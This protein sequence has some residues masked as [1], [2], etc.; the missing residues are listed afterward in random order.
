MSRHVL[1]SRM[2]NDGDVLLTTPA[3]RAIQQNGSKVSIL[4]SPR[5][6]QAAQLIPNIEEIIIFHTP[7][8]DSDPK[9]VDRDK[10][11]ELIKQIESISIDEAFIF[12]SFH[13]SPLPMALLLRLASVPFIAAISEDY[14]GS[15]LD[16]R[17]KVDERLHEVERNLSLVAT[18]GY[19]LDKN[20]NSQLQIKP[21]DSNPI[22]EK[23]YIVVHPGASVP[24]RAWSV[25][26]NIQ[27]VAALADEGYQ[28]VVTGA[29]K[30]IALTA[31]VSQGCN[32]NVKDMGGKTTLESL[33]RLIRDAD[34]LIVGNTGP[35][36]IA[37]A[38]GTPVLSLFAPT[39]PFYKWKPWMVKTVVFG[40]QSITCRG[41]RSKKCPFDT[42]KCLDS[43]EIGEILEALRSIK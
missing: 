1:I 31:K 25:E 35:A 20:D 37:A 12:T 2:D 11:F 34:A 5:G 22:L 24:A 13:Q 9:K 28:V 32:P 38:V 42:Q 30:D 4:C 7:W 6:F 40:D 23:P 39:V 41:C 19:F 10:V 14:P 26:K 18:G 8:I 16:V 43:I 36:H 21:L 29:P 15:L 27:L 17:H 33:A 3:I